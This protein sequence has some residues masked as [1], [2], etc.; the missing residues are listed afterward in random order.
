MGGLESRLLL[1]KPLRERSALVY[2]LIA[3]IPYSKPNLLLAYKPG[4]FFRELEKV[5]KYKEST[6]RAAYSRAYQQKLIERNDNLAQ[7]TT[8]GRLKIA[9]FVAEKLEGNAQ[10]M[11]IF[12][13]PEDQSSKRQKLRKIFKEWQIVQIQ[14]SVWVT[15]K[16]YREELKNL[17]AEMDLYGYVEL[18]ECA[19][20]FPR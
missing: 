17:V 2:V 9:G 18:Y 6:L 1:K 20:L 14:K 11:I 19:R 10:L 16:D 15:G 3:L 5:S 8:K 7:L 4:L 13:I 12:D